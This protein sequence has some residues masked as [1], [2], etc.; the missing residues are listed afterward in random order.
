MVISALSP[1]EIMP[2]S[3]TP[4]TSVMNLTQRVHWMHRVMKVFT[5]GPMFF[6]S[7]ARLFSA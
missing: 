4:A 1:R 6:S 7:T 2:M 3:G 5:V